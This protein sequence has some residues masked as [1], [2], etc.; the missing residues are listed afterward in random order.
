MDS[1]RALK[2]KKGGKRKTDAMKPDK[3]VINIEGKGKKKGQGPKS[4]IRKACVQG[5]GKG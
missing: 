3:N 5:E 1:I 2:I 4:L